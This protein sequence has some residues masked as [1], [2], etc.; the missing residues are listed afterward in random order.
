MAKTKTY[1]STCRKCT[2]PAYYYPGKLL[3]EAIDLKDI[4]ASTSS[5]NEESKVVSC[6]CTGENDPNSI[7]HTLDYTFPKD[8][9]EE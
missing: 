7:K 1:V 4:T 2:S 3:I 8:F 5:S 9:K 6:T